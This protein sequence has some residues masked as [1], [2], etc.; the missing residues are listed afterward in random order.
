MEQCVIGYAGKDFVVSTP[1]KDHV[2]KNWSRKRTFFELDLL[3]RIRRMALEGTYIDVGANL[4]NHALFFQHFTRCKNLICVEP[5]PISGEYLEQ[6]LRRNEW[7]GM[8]PWVLHQC[9]A[10]EYPSTRLLGGDYDGNTGSIHLL[11]A[12]PED[13]TWVTPTEAP[14]YLVPCRPL[15]HIAQGSVGEISLLKLDIEGYEHEAI[16][17]ARGILTR[18]LPVVVAELATA[19]LRALFEAQLLPYGYKVEGRYA[20]TPTYIYVPA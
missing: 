7:E 2:W 17:G 14:S 20:V 12:T 10:A 8:P 15:D 19:E 13:P 16:K 18:H 5:H 1:G 3:E 6:N 11:G 9:A 4:G